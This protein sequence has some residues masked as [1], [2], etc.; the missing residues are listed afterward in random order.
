MSFLTA[1]ERFR[2]TWGGLDWQAGTQSPYTNAQ[3][4]TTLGTSAAAGVGVGVRRC[5]IHVDRT[6]QLAGA[7]DAEFHFDFLNLTG[8][9]PDDTWTPTDYSTIEGY[10]DT[11][12][13][14]VKGYV[15][16][17]AKLAGYHWYRHGPGI[18]PP[19]PAERV[20][21]RSVVGT[22]GSDALP[23]QVAAT[24]TLRHAVRRSW[25]RTYLPGLCD[26]IMNSGDGHMSHACVDSLANAAGALLSSAIGGD[27]P[28]VVT[29][30]HL[31]AVLNVEQ[32]EVDDLADVQR[33]RRWRNASYRKLLP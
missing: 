15:H 28:L 10:L 13:A 24:I 14:A 16:P 8:G 2:L 27:F 21:S 26:N 1:Y 9:T 29:S 32:I 19:N 3:T 31:N 4:G 23:P 5:V 25:G 6:G 22:S 17:A 30:V 33:R 11:F 7:D 20:T 12:W 18:N